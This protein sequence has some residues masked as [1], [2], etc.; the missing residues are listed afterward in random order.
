MNGLSLAIQHS[1]DGF[2]LDV[3]LDASSGVTGIIGP[4]GAGKSMLLQM[5][6]GLARPASGHITFA[7]KT[8]SDAARG[9]FLAPEHRRIG[10]V[11]QDALLFPHMSVSENLDFGARRRGDAKRQNDHGAISRD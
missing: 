4:S 6:A 10:Y 8:L 7:G 5:V 3:A 2:R 1:V 11:F 9:I